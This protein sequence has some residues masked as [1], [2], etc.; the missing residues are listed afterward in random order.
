VHIP[1]PEH[2]S[3]FTE[4]RRALLPARR[5]F[6][7]MRITGLL[8]GEATAFC[9]SRLQMSTVCMACR[10]FLV[11]IN[12]P[13]RPRTPDT[14]PPVPDARPLPVPVAPA[15]LPIPLAA[16]PLPPRPLTPPPMLTMAPPC[17]PDT[18]TSAVYSAPFR[19][20]ASSISICSLMASR[21]RARLSAW[22]FNVES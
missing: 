22:A 11:R 8:A 21:V 13:T 14:N 10:A 7:G 4:A 9:A 1:Q 16:L 12:S 19:F 5:D 17:L 6:S 3:R 2:L 18:A 15:P 20:W